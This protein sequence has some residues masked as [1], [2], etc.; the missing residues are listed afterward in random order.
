MP[1]V[2]AEVLGS[3][4]PT[5]TLDL[6]VVEG[7]GHFSFMS[8]LPP[9]VEDPLKNREEFLKTFSEEVYRLLVR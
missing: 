9:G 5:G 8:T 3:G 6:R 1:S 7:I 4:M 2:Q